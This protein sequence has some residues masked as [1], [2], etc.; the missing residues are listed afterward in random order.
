MT[1]SCQSSLHLDIECRDAGKIDELRA[2]YFDETGPADGAR[3]SRAD[4][5][6]SGREKADM[7]PRCTDWRACTAPGAGYD[8]QLGAW[9]YR[10]C[11]GHGRATF[12]TPPPAC[13][14]PNVAH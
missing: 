7:T 14:V 9:R 6:R 3:Q 13:R 11:F 12:R 4:R 5:G 1:A 8:L 2:G 10:G